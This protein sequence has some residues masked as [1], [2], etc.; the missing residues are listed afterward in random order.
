MKSWYT[1]QKKM[2]DNSESLFDKLNN[3]EDKDIEVTKDEIIY[4][5]KSAME[6]YK[7]HG[8]DSRM[9]EILK[10]CEYW[11]MWKPVNPGETFFPYG[12]KICFEID[13]DKYE[14]KI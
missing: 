3:Y 12:C 8:D 13:C 10:A 14:N 9:D 1:V 2:Y 6:S 7:E 5:L 4:L 11:L